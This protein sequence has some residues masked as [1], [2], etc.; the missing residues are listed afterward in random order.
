MKNVITTD[1]DMTLAYADVQNNGWI[2]VGTGVLK[3]IPKII[4]L[5]KDK[6]R[7][8]FH[9]HIVTFREDKDM[10]EVKAFVK[11]HDLPIEGIHNTSSKSK[12]PVL[13]ELNSKLHIDDSLSV[14]L[15][16][17]AENIPCLFVN[18]GQKLDETQKELAFKLDQIFIELD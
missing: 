1:F 17:E 9:I 13:K 15:G 4:N 6:H 8:G 11:E 18:F 2:C 7:K 10:A 3:P 12:T 14:C 5:I 16:A